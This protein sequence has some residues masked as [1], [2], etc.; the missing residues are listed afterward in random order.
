MKRRFL[1]TYLCVIPGFWGKGYTPEEAYA[2]VQE[3]S[4]E[5]M[6]A[7]ISTGLLLITSDPHVFVTDEGLVG[8]KLPHYIPVPV[9]MMH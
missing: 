8:V 9:S 7:I 6:S 4:G 2:A 1:H 5:K 3:V